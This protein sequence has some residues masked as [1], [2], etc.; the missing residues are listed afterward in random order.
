M[1]GD[2]L[3][4]RLCEEYGC[5]SRSDYPTAYEITDH[6]LESI[7]EERFYI[8]SRPDIGGSIA[9]LEAI[10]DGREPTTAGMQHH[11]RHESEAP[12]HGQASG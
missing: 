4:T 2:R 9:R 10:L 7:R 5:K 6:V 3:V 12:G 11:Q 8:I 1:A